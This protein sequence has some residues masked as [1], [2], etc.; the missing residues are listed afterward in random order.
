M[1]DD[2]LIPDVDSLLDTKQFEEAVKQLRAGVQR[3]LAQTAA[4][5]KTGQADFDST[6]M[7]SVLEIEVDR[8]DK[9][10]TSFQRAIERLEKN[11]LYDTVNLSLKEEKAVEQ[12]DG[13]LSEEQMTFGPNN[14]PH[15]KPRI[16]R[17]G[18]L[19]SDGMHG[20]SERFRKG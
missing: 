4:R 6:L 12:Q 15:F 19:W 1:A 13:S 18:S 7:E 16:C 5:L 10:S 20:P 8:L 17:A 14:E 3:A 2:K 11:Y 9:L